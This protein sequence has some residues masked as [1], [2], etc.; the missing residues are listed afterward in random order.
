MIIHN[1]KNGYI[2]INIANYSKTWYNKL[3]QIHRN[4][5]PAKIFYEDAGFN[6]SM[7]KEWYIN[8]EKIKADY[9]YRKE[10]FLYGDLHRINGPAVIFCD[11]SGIKNYYISGKQY[12][13]YDD[14]KKMRIIYKISGII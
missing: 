6:K 4:K 2:I 12:N 5:H 8:G 11:G 10:W 14:Y 13:S 1:I 7:H 3:G 9:V